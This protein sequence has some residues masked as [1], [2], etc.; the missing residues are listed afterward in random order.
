MDIIGKKIQEQGLKCFNSSQISYDKEINFLEPT[1][2]SRVWLSS[3]SEASFFFLCLTFFFFLRKI[4]SE[5]TT[6]KPL[7]FAE[8]D[9]P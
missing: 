4:S 5:L 9:G 3:P 6:A 7:L 2:P 8:E 1:R